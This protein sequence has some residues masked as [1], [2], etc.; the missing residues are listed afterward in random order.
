MHWENVLLSRCYNLKRTKMKTCHKHQSCSNSDKVMY[1][2]HK[3]DAMPV[4]NKNIL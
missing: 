3:A 1:N 2:T 4:N